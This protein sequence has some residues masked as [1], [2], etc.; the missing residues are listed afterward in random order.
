MAPSA[1]PASVS[2]LPAE[3]FFRGSL[4]FLILT[5]IGMLIATGKL[6]SVACVL[7]SIA[8][9]YKGFRW[10]RRKRPELS[11]RT[12]TWLVVCYLGF[13]PLDTFFVS[14]VFVAGS[15]NPALYAALLAAV[16]FL[17]FG[18]LVWLFLPAVFARGLFLVTAS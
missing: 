11:H 2:A 7:A 8:V 17:L 13:F 15:A 10:L 5:S 4:F 9:L 6:D 18:M 3:R 14:R 16:H 1:S 12:A